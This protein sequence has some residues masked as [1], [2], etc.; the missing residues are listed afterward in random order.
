MKQEASMNKISISTK[1]GLVNRGNWGRIMRCMERAEAGEALT[2]GFIGGSITQGAVASTEENCYAHRVYTW[3]CKRF[4]KAEFTYLNAGIGATTSHF[5]VA[6]VE[7]DLLAMKPDFVVIEF[8]VNDNDESD[9]DRTAF[10]EETY[11]GLIRRIYR[12]ECEPAVVLLHNVRYNDGSTMEAV[13]A[14][15]GKAYELPCLSIKNSIYPY[16]ADGIIPN[17]DI[18]PDDLHPNDS[19]HALVAQVVT[20]FLQQVCA[21]YAAEGVS[22]TP[23]QLPDVPLTR[24]TYENAYRLQ[25]INSNPICK[26]FVADQREQTDIRDIFKKGYVATAVGDSILFEVR[27]SNIAVQYRK[28]IH[29]P[30][31]VAI[32]VLDGEEEHAVVLDGNFKETWGDKLYLETLMHHGKEGKH[33]L[34]IRIV[35][36]HD[37]DQT[38]FYLASVIVAGIDP[39][40]SNQAKND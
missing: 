33:R 28:S 31:P 11:E 14:A 27:G 7:R 38:P 5:A 24:N 40:Q 18:T 15:I 29:K 35:E 26:G 32:A 8:S 34:E 19:G 22:E 6:R 17:R 37:N 20:D 2:I 13:H 39:P 21:R 36:A 25:N 16:V 10:F 1:T 23:E 30:T 9:V 4:P 3:W 12:S